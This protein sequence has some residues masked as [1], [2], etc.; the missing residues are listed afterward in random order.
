MEGT[1][2]ASKRHVQANREVEAGTHQVEIS[3]PGYLASAFQVRLSPDRQTTYREDLQPTSEDSARARPAKS[4]AVP[5]TTFYFI[6]GC[7][8]GNVPPTE[9]ALPHGC[10]LAQLKTFDPRK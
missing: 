1:L 4:G 10:D 5:T 8:L 7:Y 2:N 3:A 9:A 6:A